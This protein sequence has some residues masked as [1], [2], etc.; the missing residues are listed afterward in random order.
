[1]NP[2]IPTGVVTGLGQLRTG[3][4]ASGT[5]RRFLRNPLGL[6][7]AI[8]L[9]IVVALAVC[10]PWLGVPD[11][12][13]VS[14][15]AAMQ[16][17]SAEHWLG[18]DSSGRDTFSRLLW[19]SR[20]NLLGATLA[21]AVAFAVGVT[22]G[23]IAGYC[24][25]WFDNVANWVN[26][27]NLAL[28]GI[29]V[30]LAVRSVAGPSVWIAMAVF[31]VLLAP[32]FFRIVRGAVMAVRGELYIDAARVSGL[33]DAR[34]I[35]RHVLTVVRAPVIIQSARLASI[36]IGVQ[37]G[38]EFLGVSDASVPSWGAMLNE[39]FRKIAL[40]PSLIL[41]PCLVIG[42]V[43]T[44]LVLL[45]NALR[46][47]LED[48]TPPAAVQPD[49]EPSTGVKQTIIQ[50]DGAADREDEHKNGPRS[51]LEV[52]GLRVAYGEGA[53]RAVVVRGVDLHVSAGKVLGLVGES[54]SG[55]SQTA[56]AILGLLSDGGRVTGGSIVFDGMQLVG[57]ES[58][59]HRALLGTQI[60]YVPQEPMSNLDP[61]FRI[62]AQLTAPMR[63][64]LKLSKREAT[65]KA[66][67]LLARV[68]IPDPQKTFDSYPHELSGGMA[69]RVLIAG[70]IS[71]NPRLLIADEPTT[72]LDV[73]VQADVLDLLR[74]LQQETGMAVILVTHNFGVVADLCDHVAVMQTGRII[75]A[76]QVEQI[77][78]AP[79]HP[80]TR[81]L[82]ESILDDVAPR[83]Y[84]F[85]DEENPGGDASPGTSAANTRGGS[86]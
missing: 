74:E 79:Q 76:G 38:L 31:G 32:G 30:V 22:S 35:G 16:G 82:L 52:E 78:A 1:M 23:L 33:S 11:P 69:Q 20:V 53:G 71:C 43:S 7:S 8:A 50:P 9:L 17:P 85:A 59:T 2:Q 86:R 10:A 15:R 41:W 61:A 13:A 72:A 48:R 42:I 57:M 14:L 75:E 3:R 58:S 18:T 54:G 4:F 49:S 55:K 44:A 80:Y 81:K 63:T 84:P 67:R 34:I 6:L 19:G 21:V 27:L 12:N 66:L 45:G 77:F 25:G 26:N 29:V 24:G 62:G 64:R 47:A 83:P 37:A 28:P 68:G 73:T 46:D 40:D 5:L 36:A 70:A 56:F 51:L 39:G 65:E 60:A